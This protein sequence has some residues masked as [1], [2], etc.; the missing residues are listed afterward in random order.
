M[1][2]PMV[3][4]AMAAAAAGLFAGAAT[5]SLNQR[6]FPCVPCASSRRDPWRTWVFR[7]AQ[8]LAGGRPHAVAVNLSTPTTIGARHVEQE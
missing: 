5:Y 2:V 1:T 7:R 8:T 6:S 3:A 4:I